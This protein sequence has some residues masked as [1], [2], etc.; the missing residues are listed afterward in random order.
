ME[1]LMVIGGAT[2]SG[3][4]AVA[5]ALA[6]KIGGEVISCDS[7]QLYRG[8]DI[9]TATPTIEEMAGVQHHLLNVSD[10][11]M[12]H[13]SAPEYREMALKVISQVKARGNIPILCGGTGLYIDALTKPRGFSVKGDDALR[14][15]L[16]K[17]DKQ[18]LHEKLASIDSAA[19]ARLNVNDTRRVIRA[20]EVFFLSGKTLTEHIQTDG[21]RPGDY[22]GLL[23]ALNWPRETLYARIDARVDEMMAAGL[24]DEVRFLR[25]SGVPRD[26]TAMQAIGYKELLAHL[27]GEEPLEMAVNRIKQSTRRYAKRQLTWFRGDSRTH[28][29]DA[30]EQNVDKIAEEIQMIWKKREEVCKFSCP[31]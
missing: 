11:A 17:L 18:A 8:M 19:A 7:M 23:F 14:A 24:L 21:G 26:A 2:A 1:N 16:L 22:E 9:G 10:P 31:K 29:L 28:W 13:L 25:A 3:K 6:R 15:E 27:A 5:V 12:D 30:E 20:L 4:S